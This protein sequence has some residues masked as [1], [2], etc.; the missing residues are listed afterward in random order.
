MEKLVRDEMPYLCVKNKNRGWTPMMY[1]VADDKEMPLLLANK[2]IEEVAEIKEAALK[3]AESPHNKTLKDKAV[4]EFADLQ[5]A[6]VELQ[7][8][9]GISDD[10]IENARRA[11][12]R[13][14]GGFTKNI[15][16][17]GNK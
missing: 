15:V 7:H 9:L 6:M 12:A 5:E 2:L 14:R 17:D 8:K 10:M 3:C 13:E 4:E 11:K 1:R 16:W